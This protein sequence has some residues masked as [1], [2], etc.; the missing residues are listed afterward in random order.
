MMV[1]VEMQRAQ[2]K[3]RYHQKKPLGSTR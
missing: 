1:Y 3:V 2:H